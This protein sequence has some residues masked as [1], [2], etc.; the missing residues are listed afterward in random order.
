[1]VGGCVVWGWRVNEKLCL[2]TQA[3]VMDT[4][5]GGEESQQDGDKLKGDGINKPQR[6]L[7]VSLKR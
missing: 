4:R 5:I 3:A 1:M 7:V 6:N 2:S